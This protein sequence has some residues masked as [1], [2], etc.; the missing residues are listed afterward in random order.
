MNLENNHH[1]NKI[2]GR[3]DK[4]LMTRIKLH[5]GL[6]LISQVEP[7]SG[8]EACKD[9]HWIQ[10]MKEQLDWIGQHEAQELVLRPKEN[11]IIGTKW[12]LKNKMN[13]HGEVVRNKARLV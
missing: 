2:I 12:I 8:D 6:C 13:E 11:N 10:E 1:A 3:K 5:E 7:K 9:D 4:G